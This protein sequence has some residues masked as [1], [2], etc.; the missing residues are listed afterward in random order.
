MKKL[1][2]LLLVI[3]SIAPLSASEGEKYTLPDLIKAMEAGNADLL[4][5]GEN[6]AKAALDTK[7]AKGAY[8]PT[9]DLLVS[10]TYMANPSL[11]NVTINPDEIKI[12][13][14]NLSDMVGLI[15]DSGLLPP[16]Y[17]GVI[18]GLLDD[19]ITVPMN[20]GNNRIQGQITLTQPIFTWGK[21]SNAV[22]LFEKVESLRSM[23]RSDKENQ[24]IAELRSR[25]DALYYINEI[26][27]LLDEIEKKADNLI[28]IAES[29]EEAGVMLSEDV[30]DAQIQKQQASISRKELEIQYDSVLEALR[31]LVGIDD[32]EAEDIIYTPDESLADK[33]LSY[34]KD[35]LSQ[36]ATD[37]SRLPLLMLSGMEDV[38]KYTK[39]IAEGGIYGKPDLALQ[40]AASYGGTIKS[41][42]WD[43]NWGL[44]IT[45][46][47]ST[48]LWDG[49]K[50]MNDIKRAESDIISASIDYENAVRT[51]TESVNTA[52]NQAELSKEKLSFA[53]MKRDADSL[54]AEREKTSLSLGSSSQSDVL[55]KEMQVLQDEIEI[56]SEKITLSQSVNTLLYLTAMDASRL[57][58]ITD[59]M[60]E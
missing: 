7:D 36:M 37:P 46:A 1:L 57:P 4:K 14:N 28:S 44:N 3:V 31:T 48:T 39:K 6:I 29:A 21:L 23:E 12:G 32:L 38:Q 9:I 25:L 43:D 26:F 60:A 10:G 35:S 41:S 54:K 40:V 18:E 33:V 24:L 5:A 55:Q 52:Y 56:V 45:L 20:M 27:P 22:K 19:P 13:D 53:E 58:A 51:I 15:G 42:G 49:G 34:G 30:L 17:S 59:G 47:L 50:K 2:I 8:T 16:E 11:G